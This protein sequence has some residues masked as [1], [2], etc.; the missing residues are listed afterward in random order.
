[1]GCRNP[2]RRTIIAGRQPGRPTANS[3][4]SSAAT[5]SH[6]AWKSRSTWTQSSP[7]A[8]APSITAEYRTSLCPQ[9]GL[10]LFG[11]SDLPGPAEGFYRILQAGSGRSV[12]RS[13]EGDQ[14]GRAVGSDIRG[15]LPG[16][17]DLEP[18][19][20]VGRDPGVEASVRAPEHV[21]KPRL[22]RHLGHAV[23][24]AQWVAV[25]KT[26]FS[27]SRWM[28]RFDNCLCGI[29]EDLQSASIF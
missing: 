21:N 10:P 12:F 4:R 2:D 14:L 17:V 3:K 19:R 25:R 20:N 6:R 29:F 27:S 18:L 5:W 8:P 16:I 11:Q 22:G 23:D 15:S 28:R 7:T 1:M 13:R 9:A 26:I 24:S